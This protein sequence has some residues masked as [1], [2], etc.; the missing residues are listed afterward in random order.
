MTSALQIEEIG[1]Q[2]QV[3]VLCLAT[4]KASCKNHLERSRG[5]FHACTRSYSGLVQ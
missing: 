1:F 3:R 2:V 4:N 5:Q